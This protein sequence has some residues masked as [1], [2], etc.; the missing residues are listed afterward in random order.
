MSFGL[1]TRD[2][3]C[4]VNAADSL[5][6]PAHRSPEGW[7]KSSSISSS[8]RSPEVTRRN[9]NRSASFL[10]WEK[11]H[12]PAFTHLHM[13]LSQI[14]EAFPVHLAGRRRRRRN[15]G[16]N[17]PGQM[18]FTHKMI[19]LITTTAFVEI[20]LPIVTKKAF[21]VDEI[22]IPNCVKGHVFHQKLT[23][24][25]ICAVKCVVICLHGDVETLG[26]AAVLSILT[27]F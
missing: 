15:M 25:V 3:G 8:P 2:F 16:K 11:H 27:L 7:R 24:Y 10:W 18:Y 14:L 12:W 21:F 26:V 23:D 13:Q 5:W 4:N 20:Q 17:K 9:R 22:K 1:V 6:G 19:W